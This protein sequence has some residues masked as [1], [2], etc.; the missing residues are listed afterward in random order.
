MQLRQLWIGMAGGRENSAYLRSDPG[1]QMSHTIKWLLGLFV[2]AVFGA[3]IVLGTALMGCQSPEHRIEKGRPTRFFVEKDYAGVMYPVTYIVTDTF[4]GCQTGVIRIN[5]G[6][7][8][9]KIKSI[10]KR[11]KE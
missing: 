7:A 9:F 8:T 5:E 10:E 11:C 1:G 2:F 4:T 6:V 3:A